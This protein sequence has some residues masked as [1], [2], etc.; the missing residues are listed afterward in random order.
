[1]YSKFQ[2][3]RFV[4]ILLGKLECRP[5]VVLVLIIAVLFWLKVLNVAKNLAKRKKDE[6]F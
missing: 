2:D 1:M 3:V 5:L 6:C 4:K